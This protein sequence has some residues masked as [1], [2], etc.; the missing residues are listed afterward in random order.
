MR[1]LELDEDTATRDLVF[2]PKCEPKCGAECQPA[3]S[4]EGPRSIFNDN[5]PHVVAV[6]AHLELRAIVI[7]KNGHRRVG[8]RD[9]P[10]SR[11]FGG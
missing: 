4:H 11:T 8:E 7:E 10:A 6:A 1:K 3:T 9:K 5:C 2:E